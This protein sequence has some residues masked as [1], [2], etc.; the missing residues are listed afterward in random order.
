MKQVIIE[1]DGVR[2][3]LVKTNSFLCCY[4]CSILKECTKFIGDH[5]PCDHQHFEK[6]EQLYNN[7]MWKPGQLVTIDNKTYQVIKYKG[8]FRPCVLCEFKHYEPDVNPCSK[9]NVYSKDA[10]IPHGCYLK[11][12][13]ANK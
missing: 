9:C 3:K 13:K 8:P 4:D 2:H 11:L 6:V 1:I 10:K 7:N 5:C 12:I